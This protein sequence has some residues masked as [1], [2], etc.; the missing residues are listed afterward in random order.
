MQIVVEPYNGAL[1]SNKNESTTD[2]CNNVDKSQ[3]HW[4][5]KD[6]MLYTLKTFIWHF[7]KDKTLGGVEEISMSRGL[8]VRRR[9]LT[10]QKNFWG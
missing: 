3:K 5:T 4:H 10:G 1:L 7:G 9:E 8:R 2:K 6:Y